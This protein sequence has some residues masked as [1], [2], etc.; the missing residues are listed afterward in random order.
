MSEFFRGYHMAC[1]GIT[2]HPS[3]S[4]SKK[5]LRSIN[6]ACHA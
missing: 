2:N 3:L 5:V 1:D 6:I 4:V